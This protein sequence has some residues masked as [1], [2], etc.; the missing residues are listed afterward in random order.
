MFRLI[1]VLVGPIIGFIVGQRLVGVDCQLSPTAFADVVATARQIVDLVRQW[2]DA[3]R[4]WLSA[5]LLSGLATLFPGDPWSWLLWLLAASAALAALGAWLARG[6]PAGATA[7]PPAQQPPPPRVDRQLGRELKNGIGSAGIKSIV[8]EARIE[9]A[10]GIRSLSDTAFE[11]CADFDIQQER[12]AL[13]NRPP[14]PECLGLSETLEAQSP[15][16]EGIGN[17]PPAEVWALRE[18]W[19]P[20]IGHFVDEAARSLR[21]GGVWPA[22]ITTHLSAGG[23]GLPGLFGLFEAAVAFPRADRHTHLSVP[24][25]DVERHELLQ[26]LDALRTG[27]LRVSDQAARMPWKD[28][29]PLA[30]TTLLRDNRRGRADLDEVAAHIAPALSAHGLLETG[31]SENM[32]NLMRRLAKGGAHHAELEPCPLTFHYAGMAV[33][34][35][36]SDAGPPVDVA[37]MMPVA[38]AALRAVRHGEGVTRALDVELGRHLLLVTVPC[39]A[40]DDVR[41]VQAYVGDRLELVG[42]P[43]PS[44][45]GIVFSGYRPDPDSRQ[46]RVLALKLGVVAGGWDGVYRAIEPD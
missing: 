40:W 16:R 13:T 38:D 45:I 19:M 10:Y 17:R 9:E 44:C 18:E 36:Q 31:R 29:R 3:L 35:A 12:I 15:L 14:G 2:L 6:K 24:E 25:A 26:L 11:A 1:L 5:S 27:D 37:T 20:A 42:P 32:S 7:T 30:M 33:P 21:A 28:D 22:R 8:R 43:D 46:E 41:Q 4:G 23:H 34:V 39:N